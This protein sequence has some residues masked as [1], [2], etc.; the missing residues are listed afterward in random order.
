M[1]KNLFF[2]FLCMMIFSQYSFA[3]KNKD[4]CVDA[5][6]DYYDVYPNVGDSGIYLDF[7]SSDLDKN[8]NSFILEK[9]LESLKY[10]LNNVENYHAKN[11]FTSLIEDDKFYVDFGENCGRIKFNVTGFNPEK[12][13]HYHDQCYNGFLYKPSSFDFSVDSTSPYLFSSKRWFDF[14]GEKYVLIDYAVN[15][16]FVDIVERRHDVK[17]K[18]ATFNFFTESYLVKVESNSYDIIISSVRFQ[19]LKIIDGN[20]A[21]VTEKCSFE[22]CGGTYYLYDGEKLDNKC[23]WGYGP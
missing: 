23:N 12:L 7:F 17:I 10:K 6:V 11:S 1:L 20:L 19:T 4:Y 3:I 15:K 13:L 14:K 22:F 21:V 2:V 16:D 9:Y 8:L 18:M 5:S